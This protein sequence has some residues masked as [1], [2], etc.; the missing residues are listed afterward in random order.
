M[1][2]TV[3]IDVADLTFLFKSDN[4]PNVDTLFPNG[5]DNVLLV[6]DKRVCPSYMSANEQV[7][8]GNAHTVD[9]RAC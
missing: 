2:S 5:V 3:H 9:P 1:P 7:P 6:L 8:V 4:V